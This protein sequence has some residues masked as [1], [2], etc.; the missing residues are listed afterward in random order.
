MAYTKR[1]CTQCGWKGPQNEMHQIVRRVEV[2]RGRNS[3]SGSTI[4]GA[5]A[6]HKASS[7]KIGNTIFNTGQR[8]Y[9]RKQKSWF[10]GTCAGEFKKGEGTAEFVKLFFGGIGVMVL[11]TFLYSGDGDGDE[12]ET[13]SKSSSATTSSSSVQAEPSETPVYEYEDEED[14]VRESLLAPAPQA[15][16]LGTGPSFDCAKASQ[17]S[18]HAICGSATLSQ[19]DLRLAASFAQARS[20]LPGTVARDLGRDL[21]KDR[22]FCGADVGCLQVEMTRAIYQFDEMSRF[23]GEEMEAAF[24]ALHNQDRIRVQR[25]LGTTGHYTSGVDGLWG[26]GTSAAIYGRLLS[27]L[28]EGGSLEHKAGPAAALDDLANWR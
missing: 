5:L 21:L 8:T 24:M 15:A 1:T 10:C 20:V 28:R 27:E 23:G 17:P 12:E 19:L 18:E 4:V 2:A 26:Q 3:I 16:S 14:E 11:A 25:N 6:G 7:R 22:Q 13:A 9:T